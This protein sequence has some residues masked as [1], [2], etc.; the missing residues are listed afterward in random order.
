MNHPEHDIYRQFLISNQYAVVATVSPEHAPQA[1]TVA[2]MT[3]S[4]GAIYFS[5]RRTTRKAINIQAGSPVAMVIGTGPG[6]TTL[7][8]EG[9]ASEL[10]GQERKD[11]MINF[12]VEKSSYYD[13]YLKLP[14][15]I[16]FIFYKLVPTW[17]RM[18]SIDPDTGN[19]VYTQIIGTPPIGHH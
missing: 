12:M 7:Q 6:A 13:I 14:G 4:N 1:A 19:E 8:I 3:D 17:A 16:D 15:G 18:L 5:T 2:Y 10:N 11:A 9:I